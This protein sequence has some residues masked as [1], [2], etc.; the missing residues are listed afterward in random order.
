MK[1]T[2]GIK[3]A[4]WGGGTLLNTQQLAHINSRRLIYIAV[5]GAVRVLC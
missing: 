5:I 2:S 1:V 4:D 3:D